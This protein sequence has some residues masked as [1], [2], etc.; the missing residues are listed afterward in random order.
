MLATMFNLVASA[1]NI[2]AKEKQFLTWFFTKKLQIKDKEIFYVD[3]NSEGIVREL[4]K[5]LDKDTL[6]SYKFNRLT[7]ELI[8]TRQEKKAVL[9]AIEKIKTQT[10]PDHILPFAK[11]I[12]ND[13][14]SQIFNGKGWD[15]AYKKGL[16]GY[17]QF[18]KPIFFRNGT[19]CIFQYGYSCGNLCGQGNTCIYKK[20]D[21]GWEE[22]IQFENWVS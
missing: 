4:K 2:S 6:K 20:T 11:T 21:K 12:T 10:L 3:K 18:H 1:Q 22:F 5:H 7:D 19:L 13:S 16:H 8:Y 9:R 17:Y 14:L 15:N